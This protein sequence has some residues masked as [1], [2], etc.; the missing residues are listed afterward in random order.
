MVLP[1]RHRLTFNSRRAKTSKN[2]KKK[3]SLVKKYSACQREVA[4]VT[5]KRITVVYLDTAPKLFPADDVPSISPLPSLL[6]S[7]VHQHACSYNH[8]SITL[9]LGHGNGIAHNS[10]G[11]RNHFIPLN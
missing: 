8:E 4:R 2:L 5:C 3:I 10:I 9:Q 7:R 6:R 11:Y 1:R